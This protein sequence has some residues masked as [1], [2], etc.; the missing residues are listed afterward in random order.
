MRKQHKFSLVEVLLALGVCAIGIC[1]VMVL[2]PIGATANRDA[3][4]ETHAAQSADQILNYLKYQLDSGDDNWN[5]FNAAM[6][7]LDD[8]ADYNDYDNP[9]NVADSDTWT[10]VTLDD[11]GNN[12]FYHDHFSNGGLYQL[13]TSTGTAG[14]SEIDDEDIDNR[15]IFRVI[16]ADITITRPSPQPAFH[17]SRD[18]GLRLLVEASWPAELPYANRQKSVYSLDVFK[19]R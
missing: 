7:S 3:S 10:Q 19:R 8:F 17:V 11:L 15:M 6:N 5:D 13:V 2:F 4:L 1:S 14:P 16:V 12:I 9:D 18:Y